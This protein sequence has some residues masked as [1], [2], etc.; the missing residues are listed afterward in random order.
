MMCECCHTGCDCGCVLSCPHHSTMC[1][2]CGGLG[3]YIGIGIYTGPPR[4]ARCKGE[5]RIVRAPTPT[6]ADER[7][8]L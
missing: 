4:C 5:G 2:D 3:I 6:T 7:P 1:P 8:W